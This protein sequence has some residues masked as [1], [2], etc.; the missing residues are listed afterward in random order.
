MSDS[1]RHST[2]HMTRFKRRPLLLASVA[3][4]GACGTFAHRQ[5]AAAKPPEKDTAGFKEFSANVQR[6]VDLHNRLNKSLPKL[7]N[8]ASP[9]AI[10]THQHALAG[11]IQAARK[12]AREGDIFVPNAAKAF[13]DVIAREFQGPQGKNAR[14]TMRQGAPLNNVHI[15][16][17]QVYPEA[18]P[19]TSVPPTLLLKLPK[20]P[21]ELAYRIA[22]RDL[23]LLDL[24][25]N[26]VVDVLRG[27]L[28]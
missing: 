25:A 27:A 11:R 2:R 12:N 21:G 26:L 17:N 4:L 3:L 24:K 15:R 28:P 20:L 22:D 9:A 23:L 6:Y 10:A 7:K 19:Y 14:A 8:H 16:V 5:Q 18:L 13:Q 1:V